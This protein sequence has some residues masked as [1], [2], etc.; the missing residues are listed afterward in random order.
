MKT[1][2]ITSLAIKGLSGAVSL[3]GA[4]QAYGAVV[5]ADPPAMTAIAADTLSPVDGTSW[6][7]DGDGTLDF[8]L[9]AQAFSK[10]AFDS[11][12]SGAFTGVFG[13]YS[14]SQVVG[15]SGSSPSS[16]GGTDFFGANLSAGTSVGPTS[17]FGYKPY[18]YSTL[19]I[20][21]GR[22]T[23]G[24]FA[25]KGGTTGFVGFEFTEADGTHYGYGEFTSILQGTGSKI[26]ATLIY[27]GGYYETTPNTP[28]VI[29]AV[30]EPGSL[31]ALAFGLAGVAGAA[32]YRRKQAA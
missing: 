21:Y 31:A 2:T 13:D 6:D 24:Q 3:A 17:A 28:I 11:S 27:D 9:G 25:A 32:A 14:L 10:G 8:F 29:G 12:K 4:T 18:Y 22:K 19:G 1:S 15:Y 26:T 16:F 7:V 23:Y 5:A 30:P 20:K